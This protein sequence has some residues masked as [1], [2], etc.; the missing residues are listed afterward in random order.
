MVLLS[1]ISTSPAAAEGL[2]E[3]G[4]RAWICRPSTA[5]QAA[6]E[7][8]VEPN[9]ASSARFSISDARFVYR[10]VDFSREA[11][12]AYAAPRYGPLHSVRLHPKGEAGQ[13]NLAL[14]ACSPDARI[15]G[16]VGGEYEGYATYEGKPCS[17]SLYFFMVVGEANMLSSTSLACTPPK[18]PHKHAK[19]RRR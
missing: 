6:V 16:C 13:F 10:T 18:K 19:R 12:G 8:V 17:E 5:G 9:E 14:P 11:D 4:C 7:G 15:Y 3:P 1:L 2:E